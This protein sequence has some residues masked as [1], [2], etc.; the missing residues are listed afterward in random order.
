MKWFFFF[1]IRAL[2][3]SPRTRT[4]LWGTGNFP[5]FKRNET[6][7]LPFLKRK[8]FFF[9]IG[10]EEKSLSLQNEKNTLFPII[11]DKSHFLFKMEKTQKNTLFPI[12]KQKSHFL[13]KMGI[14]TR[15]DITWHKMTSTVT[16]YYMTWPCQRMPSTVTW[17]GTTWHYMTW[18]DKTRH[19]MIRYDTTWYVMTWHQQWHDTTWHDTTCQLMTSTV[20]WCYTT[21]HDTTWHDITWPDTT[22][23]DT[24]W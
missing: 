18:H 15:Y 22:R 13:F 8:W 20:T 19:D 3:L 6:I 5:V 1:C 14:L 9:F 21:R 2:L 17:H 16:C 24:I 11:K 7:P 10:E 12:I 23:H 4:F